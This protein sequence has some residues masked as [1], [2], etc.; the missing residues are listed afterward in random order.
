MG[1]CN[2]P[3]RVECKQ[4]GACAANTKSINAQAT[5]KYGLWGIQPTATAAA[6]DIRVHLCMVSCDIQ[7]T[8]NTTKTFFESCKD[9]TDSTSI[10][11]PERRRQRQTD[12]FTHQ[13]FGIHGGS[14]YDKVHESTESLGL[15]VLH[16]VE[17]VIRGMIVGDDVTGPLPA[18]RRVF[19]CLSRSL[20][21]IIKKRHCVNILLFPCRSSH[22][23]LFSASSPTTMYSM[24]QNAAPVEWSPVTPPMTPPSREAK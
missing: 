16:V 13:L 14:R 21:K 4:H 19:L 8:S 5:Y 18:R 1:G 17:L 2:Q 24:F 23:E 22:Q 11:F 7:G 9:H 12:V 15:R 3:I 20:W 6:K 10:Y